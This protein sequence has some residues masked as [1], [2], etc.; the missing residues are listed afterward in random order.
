LFSLEGGLAPSVFLPFSPNAA[1]IFPVFFT[2]S[3]LPAGL[4]RNYKIF[5]AHSAT[6]LRF[7]AVIRFSVY[8]ID[9]CFGGLSATKIMFPQ[10]AATK[11]FSQY[12]RFWQ[13][14][15]DKKNIHVNF[16]MREYFSI[17]TIKPTSK[18]FVVGLMFF[19]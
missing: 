16:A 5:F 8:A 19:W 3:A 18:R 7:V 9:L 1:S 6:F 10:T 14:A 2:L 12:P 13:V 17:Y 4:T 11:C 15:R